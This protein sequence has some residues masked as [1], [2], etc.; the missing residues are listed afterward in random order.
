MAVEGG[1]TSPP[2]TQQAEEGEE[3]G[4]VS[5]EGGDKVTFTEFKAAVRVFQERETS[6]NS[7]EKDWFGAVEEEKD[8]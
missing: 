2:H 4:A 6:L 1:T 3:A 7:E 8:R 5:L